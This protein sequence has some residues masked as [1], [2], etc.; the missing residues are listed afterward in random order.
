MEHCRSHIA[1]AA[2]ATPM[3]VVSRVLTDRLV[4]FQEVGEIVPA[5]AFILQYRMESLDISVHG[6]RLHRN[7][8]MNHTQPLRRLGGRLKR[9]D[10]GRN[11][12]DRTTI[13]RR[14]RLCTPKLPSQLGH[15]TQN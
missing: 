15:N 1:D 13:V 2:M 9:D 3:V 7:A 8:F 4:G 14:L 11:W 10:L 5:V 6:R 12:R